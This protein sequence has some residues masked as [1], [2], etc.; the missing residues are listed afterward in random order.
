M[1]LRSAARCGIHWTPGKGERQRIILGS[2]LD[3]S[4]QAHKTNF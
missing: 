2:L 4:E 3:S 1:D